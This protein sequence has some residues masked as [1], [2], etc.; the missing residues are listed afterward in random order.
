M[1]TAEQLAR[2]ERDGFLVVPG[3]FAAEEVERAEGPLHGRCARRAPTP[4]TSTAW[5]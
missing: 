4:A 1:I 2:Y 5:T 3:L